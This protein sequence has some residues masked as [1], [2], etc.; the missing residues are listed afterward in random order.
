MCTVLTGRTWLAL[1]AQKGADVPVG[2]TL[3]FL[4]PIRTKLRTL[5]LLIGKVHMLSWKVIWPEGSDNNEQPR[6]RLA[7]CVSPVVISLY[8]PSGQIHQVGIQLL[9]LSFALVMLATPLY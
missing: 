6:T 2:W 9:N 8:A 4:Q 5:S 3:G 1:E 7:D